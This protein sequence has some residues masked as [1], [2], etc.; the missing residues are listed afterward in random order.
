MIKILILMLLATISCYSQK[1][2]N[3]M[4]TATKEIN[5]VDIQFYNE[6]VSSNRINESKGYLDQHR[7]DGTLMSRIVN[8]QKDNSY[9]LDEYDL[10]GKEVLVTTIIKNNGEIQRQTL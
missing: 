2:L 4:K 1:D 7:K 10:M 3:K 5:K 6:L 9:Q 8:N